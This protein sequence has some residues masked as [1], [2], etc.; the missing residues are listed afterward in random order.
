MFMFLLF[1]IMVT[2]LKYGANNNNQNPDLLTITL[3]QEA[4]DDFETVIE[5][6]KKE[7]RWKNIYK[8]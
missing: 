6:K 2:L 1:K 8:K 7:K 4:I 5:I 3:P